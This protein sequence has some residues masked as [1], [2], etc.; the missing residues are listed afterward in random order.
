MEQ[1]RQNISRTILFRCAQYL[2][3]LATLNTSQL[4]LNASGS[5]STRPPVPRN[6]SGTMD[7]AK[8]SLGQRLFTD[9]PGSE[10]NSGVPGQKQR[11]KE[12][13]QSLPARFD[14]QKDLT[15][16]AGKLSLE[17]LEAIEYYVAERFAGTQKKTSG[18]PQSAYLPSK[19]T[20]VVGVG[21]SFTTFD[22]F[23]VGK[24]KVTP[25]KGNDESLNQI[26]AFTS[27]EYG[28]TENIAGDITF[29]YTQT[30]STSTFG[31]KKDRG[32]ADTSIGLRYGM[33]KET[34]RRPALTLR[35]G[36]I[37]RGSYDEN[38]PF[39]AGDGANGL[40][41]SLIAGKT[42]GH[43]GFGV[44]GDFGYRLRENPVPDD[45]FGSLGVF[46]QFND[47]VQ[48]QDALSVSVGYRH[49][50]SLSG[51]DIMGSGWNPSA[52]ASS[53]FPA[54]KE[55]NQLLESSIGYSDQKGRQYQITAAKSLDGR[56]T[57]DKLAFYFSISVPF[58]GH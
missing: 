23:W 37:I 29:G 1:M 39:S 50:Q 22:E 33:V 12:M 31:N 2:F 36:G 20:I 16:L 45:L 48:D 27:F 46:K 5:Y 4:D 34:S 47:I 15:E 55:I 13:Q 24:N 54:L 58:G 38:T 21:M 9:G 10:T 8:Y 52:G 18:G 3:I 32:L 28:I 53:G 35:G 49:I 42:F 11:L 56:N 57:G 26:T 19:G 41:F 14:G 6:E 43:S 25:L 40:E 17:Q 30:S 44:Y 51:L 7:R